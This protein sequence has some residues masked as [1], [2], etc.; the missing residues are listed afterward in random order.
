MEAAEAF[1]VRV[2]EF[3][4]RLFWTPNT[5][6]KN[7]RSCRSP[8]GQFIVRVCQDSYAV[9]VWKEEQKN[10][11]CW[12][13]AQA[14]VQSMI[15]G[16]QVIWNTK[17][18]KNRKTNFITSMESEIQHQASGIATELKSKGH[19]KMQLLKMHSNY[20]EEKSW[21]LWHQT[22]LLQIAQRG[23]IPYQTSCN[24][25]IMWESKAFSRTLSWS[26]LHSFSASGK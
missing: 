23:E 5:A 20:T 10:L 15:G 9:K 14:C 4:V 13:S 11:T 19:L 12:G 1:W 18:C 7:Y 24:H 2:E 26:F 25:E 17:N 6:K 8:A 22:M 3:G 21:K 16:S